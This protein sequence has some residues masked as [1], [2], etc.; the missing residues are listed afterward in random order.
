MRAVYLDESG[1][2]DYYCFGALIVDDHS[3]RAIE[4]GLNEVGALL[5]RNIPA[6]T[7]R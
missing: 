6:S 5:A 2:D 4:T 7:L 3:V 1:N